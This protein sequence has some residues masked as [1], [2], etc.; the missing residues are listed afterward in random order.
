VIP[1]DYKRMLEVSTRRYR[2]GLS[3]EEAL[4]MAFEKNHRDVSGM[5]GIRG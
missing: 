5:P 2:A 1:K 3:G 4:M